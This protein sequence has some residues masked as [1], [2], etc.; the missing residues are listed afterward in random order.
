MLKIQI[1]EK[2]AKFQVKKNVWPYFSRIIE[3]EKCQGTFF[4]GPEAILTNTVELI[5]AFLKVP[6]GC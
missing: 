6:K 4:E 5:G 1:F 3:Q 2:K